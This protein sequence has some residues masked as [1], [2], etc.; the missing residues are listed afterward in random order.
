M[1]C[2][3]HGAICTASCNVYFE[4]QQILYNN[5]PHAIGVSCFVLFCNTVFY[6]TSVLL[7]WSS[8]DNIMLIKS[9]WEIWLGYSSIQGEMQNVCV[10]LV[11]NLMDRPLGKPSIHIMLKVNW[12][13]IR[14]E[15]VDWIH[16]A[17][18]VQWP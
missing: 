9:V 15:H 7:D 10:I 2:R 14:C 4:T 16:L 13:E 6:S 8:S 3:K 17:K 18:M 1:Y 5:S 12:N 11:T